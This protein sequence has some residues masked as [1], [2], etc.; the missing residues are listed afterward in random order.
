MQAAHTSRE[1]LAA[2][3]DTSRPDVVPQLLTAFDDPR[4][5][6]VILFAAPGWDF[7]PEEYLGGHGGLE[8]E[9]LIVPLY[10]AGPGIAAGASWLPPGWSTS[11]PR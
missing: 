9:E 3:A 4:S 7:S 10:M 11:C 1:W 2:T 6:D 8:R 5:G